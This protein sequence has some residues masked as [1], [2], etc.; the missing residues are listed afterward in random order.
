MT[1]M[2][3]TDDER[4]QRLMTDSFKRDLP[5]RFYKSVEVSDSLGILLDGRNVKTPSKKPLVL[6]NLALAN[7]VAEEWRAQDAH[8]NSALMPVT[9]LANT[10][11][12]RAVS[13]RENI[14]AEIVS[15]AGNDMVC[16]WADRPPQ[17]VAF[18]CQHWQPIL[19]WAKVALGTAPLRATGLTHEPQPETLLQAVKV[20]AGSLDNWNLTGLFLLTTLTG[21]SLLSLM[22]QQGAL[23]AEAAWAA[24]NAEEDYQISQWGLDW[25]AR[26]RR[27]GRQNDFNGLVHFLALLR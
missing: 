17:L 8:I 18:Q 22:R 24:A 15:Y 27:E 16:Y 19:D 13:E 9:K 23:S 6:P 1:A 11:I 10:A 25:E 26:I 2:T 12:D 14:I 7:L 21:S 20:K 5:K 3:E 4:M